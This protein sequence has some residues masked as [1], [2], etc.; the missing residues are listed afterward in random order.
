VWRGDA[1]STVMQW[2]NDPL[3]NRARVPMIAR[4][5]AQYG[6][7]AVN[8]QETGYLSS[9]FSK[10]IFTNPLPRSGCE[11]S[12]LLVMA[13]ILLLSFAIRRYFVQGLTMGAVK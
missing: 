2:C 11:K 9:A 12:G 3:T 5:Q 4:T 1:K 8:T 13:P 6:S 10:R 7:N